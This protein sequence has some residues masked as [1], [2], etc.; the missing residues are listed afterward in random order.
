MN[1]LKL[2]IIWLNG[3]RIVGRLFLLYLSM[4]LFWLPFF[5]ASELM[6]KA[7]PQIWKSLIAALFFIV[8]LPI[9]AYY[10]AR[11]CKEFKDEIE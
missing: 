9:S 2:K 8:V 10:A 3:W 11:W 7:A 1:I 4:L 6:P 5:L